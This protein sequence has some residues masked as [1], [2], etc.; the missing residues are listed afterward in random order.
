MS[1]SKLGN[2][3]VIGLAGFG[4]T[5]LILQC[6][7]LGW[8]G[9]APVLWLGLIFG[10]TAQLLAGLMEFKT[11]NSFGMCAFTGYGAFWIA[12]CLMIIFKGVSPVF[13]W[14]G[15]DLGFFLMGWTLFTFLLFIA[16]MKHNGTLAFVFLTLLL[17]FI[18]LDVKE[19]TESAGAGLFAG[20]D[21]IICALSAFYL[22]FATVCAEA[23]IK[24]PVGG[25]WIK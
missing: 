25:P 11:G 4:M 8:C 22:M 6:H 18:G 1:E 17:G 19:L 12:L 5:T 14:V 13:D 9:I 21:L 20:W 23:G 2:P 24:L 7:N 3:A 10:G 16:S 15:K